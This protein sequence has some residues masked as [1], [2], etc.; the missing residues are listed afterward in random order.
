[1]PIDY[2]MD[3]FSDLRERMVRIET[4]LD[5]HAENHA[6]LKTTTDDHEVRIRELEDGRS[7][8][9]GMGILGALFTGAA[10]S[11]VFEILTN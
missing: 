10:G 11:K 3:V 1:M 6:A 8:L 4:K 7:K 5:A 2:P 9:L